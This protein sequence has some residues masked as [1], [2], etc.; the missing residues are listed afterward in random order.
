MPT[1]LVTGLFLMPRFCVRPQGCL[2]LQLTYFLTQ[3][4]EALR[5]L[6]QEILDVVGPTNRPTYGDIRGMKYL[7]AFINGILSLDAV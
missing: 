1:G 3:H 7:R 5:R 4:P 2:Q 6:R